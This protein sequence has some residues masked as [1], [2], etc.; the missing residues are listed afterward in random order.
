MAAIKLTALVLVI[1]A[2][3]PLP[4]L[5]QLRT[6][7]D[8]GQTPGWT[9][10]PTFV[11]SN[12]WDDNV[13][14]AG[15]GAETSGDGITILTPILD[16][17]YRA[18]YHWL[19]FGYTGSFSAYHDLSEL[20]TFDQQ[21][22]VDTRHLLSKRV[23]L[24]L[25][26]GFASVPTTEGIF[27]SGIPFLRTGSRLNDFGARVSVALDAHTTLTGGYSFQWVAFDKDAPFAEFLHG[28]QAHG[29]DGSLRRQVA[30]RITV[31]GDFSYRRALVS[32]DA[33]RFDIL[34]GAGFVSIQATR[35]LTLSGGLGF[36]RL[37]DFQELTSQ[38]GPSWNVNLVQRIERAT[39]SAGYVRSYVPSFGLGGT[40]QNEEL[41]ADVHMPVAKNRA[42]VQ[43][44]L[45][46][47]RN[48]PL[49]PGELDLKS[50]WF[51]TTAG[52]SVMR[53]LRLEGYYWRSQ[54]DSQ[55]A[56]GRMNRN[57]IGVQAVTSLPMRIK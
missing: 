49:T 14:L 22:R 11:L 38:T 43:V 28:G 46:W 10:T 25:H 48:E 16:A 8:P 19:A 37:K 57:R 4:A 2:A 45:S 55:V 6:T 52:Y 3:G 18:R 5:A 34:D 17:Q 12:A 35:T 13:I 26:D 7:A 39:L 47:R 40:I 21:L 32:D 50:L 9:I 1:V 56:G 29:F 20:N 54:Q 15:E 53:W 51:Q 41:N 44:G 33:G 30:K 24:Q 27:L 42:Y 31:G 36:S 23:T